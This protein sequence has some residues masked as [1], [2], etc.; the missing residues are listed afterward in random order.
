M[1]TECNCD[2]PLFAYLDWLRDQGWEVEE[3]EYSLPS[4]GD[5]YNMADY[6]LYAHGMYTESHMALK[7]GSL[8]SCVFAEVALWYNHS[9]TAFN[10]V[11]DEAPTLYSEYNYEG[12]QCTSET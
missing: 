12:L 3:D 6:R 1:I 2:M 11:S 4:S 9:T 10:N 8:F 7:G 5:N